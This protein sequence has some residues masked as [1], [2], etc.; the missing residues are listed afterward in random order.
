MCSLIK[1]GARNYD[2]FSEVGNVEV[3][4]I[5]FD[6]MHVEIEP[7]K[8]SEMRC[9]TQ[10]YQQGKDGMVWKAPIKKYQ[11]QPNPEQNEQNRKSEFVNTRKSGGKKLSRHGNNLV[12]SGEHF[13]PVEQE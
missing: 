8:P 6:P 7:S 3:F 4:V 5:R 12:G 11:C 10:E 2:L 9:A 13:S 1:I